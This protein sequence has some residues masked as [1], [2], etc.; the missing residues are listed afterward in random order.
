MCYIAA[1]DEARLNEW[2]TIQ[3]R[4]ALI[5]QTNPDQLERMPELAAHVNEPMP[6]G[7]VR[8]TRKVDKS[9]SIRAGTRIRTL[10]EANLPRDSDCILC[11]ELLAKAEKNQKGQIPGAMILNC[12][13]KVVHHQC[14]DTA[15]EKAFELDGAPS[16]RC[17]HCRKYVKDHFKK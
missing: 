16:P 15:F 10:K 7:T 2:F 11:Y 8:A 5:N 4:I 17:P 3:D 12:C 6:A 1:F 14:L 13:P 9:L